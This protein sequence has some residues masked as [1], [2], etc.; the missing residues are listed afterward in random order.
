MFCQKCG[1]EINDEAVVCVNCGCAVKTTSNKNK[2]NSLTDEIIEISGLTTIPLVLNII[3]LILLLTYCGMFLGIVGGV[4][5]IVLS[6]IALAKTKN[7]TC[8]LDS[9]ELDENNIHV[10]K[11]RK[12]IKTGTILGKIAI[13]VH[14]V[15]SLLM[16]ILLVFAI[17][18]AIMS[19]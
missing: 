12:D 15:L 6:A 14:G 2:S 18:S 5:G 1:T 11:I 4:V 16:I 7:I 13:A 10:Q 9:I 8:K 19:A 17:V 3:S